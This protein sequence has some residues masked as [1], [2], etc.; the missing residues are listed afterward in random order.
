LD[1]NC[2]T[3]RQIRMYRLRY[4]SIHGVKADQVS[5]TSP[6]TA[7]DLR[8]STVI[9]VPV[10]KKVRNVNLK[11]RWKHCKLFKYQRFEI[12]TILRKQLIQGVLVRV[13]NFSNS[14]AVILQN[15]PKRSV[16]HEDFTHN[17]NNFMI[18]SVL[19]SCLGVTECL[20]FVHRDILKEHNV[21]EPE[22]NRSRGWLSRYS[23]G[24]EDREVGVWV[25]V[26]SRIFSF[27]RRPDRL[28]GPPSLLYSGYR[29][30]FPRVK[31]AG[32]W[33]WPLTS[34]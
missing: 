14:K 32:A 6:W 19:F 16:N 4:N 28:R 1:Y 2:R 10:P 11:T 34:N 8:K 13:N 26:Q 30:P 25:P 21:W 31:A 27:P 18:R 23:Y 17:F 33:S 5:V 22:F 15:K 9:S 29:G 3:W 7:T 12:A 24:L 20:D